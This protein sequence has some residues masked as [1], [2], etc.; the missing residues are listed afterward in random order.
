MLLLLMIVAALSHMTEAAV[1]SKQHNITACPITVYGI[2][3]TT[4]YV[5]EYNGFLYFCFDGFKASAPGD[6]LRTESSGVGAVSLSLSDQVE[7]NFSS[8]LDGNSTCSVQFN[9]EDESNGT[10]LYLE[11]S[12]ETSAVDSIQLSLGVGEM[13]LSGCRNQGVVLRRN[14]KA[15]LSNGS[16]GIC[17]ESSVFSSEPCS[18]CHKGEC[19]L[20]PWCSVT[21][22]SISDI[23]GVLTSIPD[24]CG[25]S[26]LSRDGLRL[27]AVFRD[28]RRTDVS[29]L[30]HISLTVGATHLYMGPGGYKLNGSAV[31][32]STLQMV[33]GLSVSRTSSEMSLTYSQEFDLHFNGHSALIYFRGLDVSAATGLCIDASMELNSAKLSELSQDGCDTAHTDVED[34]TIDCATATE[35][36]NLLNGSV[37]APCHAH[38]DPDP[39]ISSCTQTLCS[40][41]S[42][43]GLQCSFH[44]TYQALCSRANVTLSDWETQ[45]HCTDAH[46][47]CQGTYCSE[48]E[49]C[50]IHLNKE[51]CFCR[52][53]FAQKYRSNK[54]FGEP[55]ECRDNS[56]T[57]YLAK[58]LLNEKGIKEQDLLLNDANDPQCRGIMQPETHMIKFSFDSVHPCGTKFTSENDMVI[59]SNTIQLMNQTGMVTRHDQFTLDF[60]CFYS[61]PKIRTVALRI[62]DSSVVQQLVSGS[63]SYNLTMKSFLDSAHT[64]PVLPQT[65]LGL[66]QT[67]WVQLSAAGLNPSLVSIVVDSC[68][69]TSHPQ[70]NSTPKYDLVQQGCPNT[71]DPTVRVVGNGRGTSSVFFF[72]M[73]QFKGSSDIFLHCKVMLCTHKSATCAPTCGSRRR[74]SIRDDP[75]PGLITLSWST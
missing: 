49:F 34:P 2:Q 36:C 26:L 54:M 51:M 59:M 42:E 41:P 32:V 6:C 48:H 53:V 57:L 65:D 73:F 15:C 27:G 74:R 68:W 31:N 28:R 10:K 63:W 14:S 13:L 56:A 11:I 50:G 21:G 22:F 38:V 7:S 70:S 47:L 33:E 75:N 64:R 8:Q 25:Y 52:A 43:D 5:S 40:Y 9:I 19:L 62:R 45:S 55:T 23:T 58:C 12:P 1:T 71:K 60:S 35:H 17:S 46:G 61:Q 44:H 66:D 39:F 29:L 24:R 30:D 3:H 18:T 69:A 67:V 72:N 16:V 37:F 20:E 4:V